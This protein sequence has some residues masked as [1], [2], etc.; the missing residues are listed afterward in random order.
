MSR[1]DIDY[2]HSRDEPRSSEWILN[3]A[4][5]LEMAMNAELHAR[6]PKHCSLTYDQLVEEV[7]D[8]YLNIFWRYTTLQA[9]GQPTI[10]K[11]TAYTGR[12]D[13]S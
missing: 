10:I 4:A 8:K 9:L 6:W 13:E 1:P 2:P 7:T 3:A 11:L 12:V 5:Q